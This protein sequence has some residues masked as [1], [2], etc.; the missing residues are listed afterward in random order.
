MFTAGEGPMVTRLKGGHDCMPPSAVAHN[1]VATRQ[2]FP[3]HVFYVAVRETKNYYFERVFYS[4]VLL[5]FMKPRSV[6]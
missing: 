4:I 1:I 6:S 3:A 2:H 5:L